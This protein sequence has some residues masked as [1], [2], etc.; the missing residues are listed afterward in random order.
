MKII[1]ISHVVVG[2]NIIASGY[3]GKKI[4]SFIDLEING[5]DLIEFIKENHSN[6]IFNFASIEEMD[7][8]EQPLTAPLLDTGRL[9]EEIDY[10]ILSEFI[11][12]SN[13]VK[14]QTS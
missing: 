9:L 4:N 10:E 8:E 6:Y 11:T 3:T 5:E 14:T 2:D 13:L 1:I 12:E 7:I